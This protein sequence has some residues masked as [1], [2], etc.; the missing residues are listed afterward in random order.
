M[1]TP[2]EAIA[3]LRER[4]PS[5]EGRGPWDSF[6]WEVSDLID[7]MNDEAL[8]ARAERLKVTDAEI[9][10][11]AYRM[12]MHFVNG[13]NPVAESDWIR[14]SYESKL[15]Y[16]NMARVCLENY[17]QLPDMKYKWDK[18]NL[19]AKDSDDNS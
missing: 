4:A 18:A 11:C 1:I 16:I 8:V 14:M 19:A 5:Y 15:Y 7:R 2:E 12:Y 13:T 6:L 17:V 3:G 10:Y 9:L